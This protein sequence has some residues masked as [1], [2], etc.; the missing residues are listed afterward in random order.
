[1][2]SLGELGDE[3]EFQKFILESLTKS[4]I[5]EVNGDILDSLVERMPNIAAV[6]YDS[7][8]PEN[9]DIIAKFEDIDDDCDNNGIPFVKIEDVPKAEDG[10]GLDSLPGLLFWKN[11]VPSVFSGEISDPKVRASDLWESWQ[12]CLEGNKP[13]DNLVKLGSQGGV[14]HLLSYYDR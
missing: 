1:M 10:F 9:V 11:G 8:I 12:N 2:P 4:D 7:E 3:V 13:N 14:F 5:E 6:F